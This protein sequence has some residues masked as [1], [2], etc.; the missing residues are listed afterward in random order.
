MA[1][2][3]Q[4]RAGRTLLGVLVT[5]RKNARRAGRDLY[6]GL[7]VTISALGRMLG[8]RLGRS[9]TNPYSHS[10]IILTLL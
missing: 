5:K 4:E 3:A 9:R 2:D 1:A 8:L 7:H 6:E 10:Q